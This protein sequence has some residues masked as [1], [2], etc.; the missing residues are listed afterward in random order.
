MN[1][2]S[3]QE[4]VFHTYENTNKNITINATAGSGK[5]TVIVE[6]NNRKPINTSSL[7]LAYNKRIQEALSER[8]VQ[9][10]SKVATLHSLGLLA[11]RMHYKYVK[12][13]KNKTFTIIKDFLEKKKDKKIKK[14]Y[15]SSYYLNKM[16]SLWRMN[17]CNNMKDF[18]KIAIR[19]DISLA[20]EICYL[21]HCVKLVDKYNRQPK[22]KFNKKNPFIV[23]FDDMIYLTATNNLIKLKQYDE[24]FLD[25]AQDANQLMKKIVFKSKKPNGRFIVVGDTYQS[26]YQFNGSDPKVFKS[27]MNFKNTETLSL[28][29]SYRCPK[30]VVNEARVFYPEMEAFSQNNVGEV[31]KNSNVLYEVKGGDFV[32]CRLNAPLFDAY[33]AL[34][35]KGYECTIGDKKLGDTLISILEKF[36]GDDFYDLTDFFIDEK[37][38]KI[39]NLVKRFKVDNPLRHPEITKFDENVQILLSLEEECKTISKLKSFLH[40]VFKTKDKV[41]PVLLYTIHKSKGLETNN[42]YLIRPDLVPSPRATTPEMIE[43]ERNLMFVAI[44]RA[45]QKFGYDNIN[46]H[47]EDRNPFFQ[48]Y[49]KY[50]Y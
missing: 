50:P 24:V 10:N 21:E 45:K 25:E 44:T 22:S 40:E 15:K 12:I 29:I 46:F 42:V 35:K 23:D 49:I 36:K 8:I 11:L 38:K 34:T 5:T 30:S 9:P 33:L 26:I 1:W 37:N 20:Y 14:I 27:F 2:S 41:K 3:H 31:N 28:P 48:T 13:D 43:Q 32:L 47:K 39:K 18:E 7:L 19:N 17:L 6:M 16:I 4:K